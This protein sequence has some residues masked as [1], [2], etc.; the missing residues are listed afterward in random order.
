MQEKNEIES[1]R[2]LGNLVSH[3]ITADEVNQVSGAR[4]A[5]NGGHWEVSGG[6]NNF[7]GDYVR[8]YIWVY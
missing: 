8:D 3:V 4:W 7:Y 2:I 1:T 6:G 5:G